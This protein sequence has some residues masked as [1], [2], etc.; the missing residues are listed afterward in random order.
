MH[1]RPHSVILIAHTELSVLTMRGPPLKGVYIIG[2][3]V[4]LLK[5]SSSH[6]SGSNTSASSP[7]SDGLRCVSMGKYITTVAGGKYIGRG[8]ASV[9]VGSELG[10]KTPFSRD[11]R[12]L[13]GTGGKRRRV[14]LMTA[15][16]V[17]G[18]SE[19][20]RPKSAWVNRLCCAWED[21]WYGRRT[22]AQKLDVFERRRSVTP[23]VL[24]N[25]RAHSARDVWMERHEVG[26]EREKARG[27]V[28]AR[29]ENV[30]ELIAD[31]LGICAKYYYE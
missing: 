1:G 14:S 17:R 6:R 26:G 20:W 13:K 4:Y 30:E 9:K 23:A 21:S 28:A 27:G 5:R 11:S 10:S 16:T 3:S 2:L 19:M 12:M 29:E 25:L 8:S 15:C 31:N 18:R 24:E 7:H 22:I